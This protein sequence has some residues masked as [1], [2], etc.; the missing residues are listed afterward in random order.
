M[1]FDL[2]TIPTFGVAGNFTGHLEQA[3]EAR[4]FVN[5]KTKDATAPKGIF[6]TYLPGA[7][8]SKII[9]EYLKCNP[10]DSSKIVF[11]NE[12]EKLQIEC[13]CV[14]SC[15]LE[16]KNHQIINIKPIA[17]AAS[18]DCS[19]RKEGAIKISE[20]KNWGKAS[21]GY[22]Q[23]FIE[24]DSFDENGLINNY[25]I[26]CFLR[27]ENELFE[28]GENSFVKDYSYIYF[29]LTQWHKEKFNY[30]KDEGPLENLSLY[31]Q[32]LNEPETIMVSIGA[33]RYTKW[34]TENF[35]KNNDES[36]V[37]VYPHNKYSPDEIKSLIQ[38]KD[39]SAKDI[40]FLVQSISIG[41][42]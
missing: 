41:C 29:Q 11:P 23:N 18:N 27:R 20:K 7:N 9:P 21:K 24:M 8:E 31:L 35:L 25:R 6:P 34:G 13:E 16:W 1:N 39:Y 38:N 4:D 26:A 14:I 15:K 10:F 37:I 32:E 19:I 17:F 5:V 33:T 42:K 22:S 40:S 2:N 28:Y 36:I 3:G 30:Q 12:D